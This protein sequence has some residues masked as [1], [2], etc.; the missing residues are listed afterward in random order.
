MHSLHDLLA[1]FTLHLGRKNDKFI[2]RITNN[3]A[4]RT[5]LSGAIIRQKCELV[6]VGDAKKQSV[7][8]TKFYD[9]EEWSI[10]YALLYSTNLIH[11][12]R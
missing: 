5:Y 2:D 8:Q 10:I 11:L 12:M 1:Q 7:I 6:P 9:C 4:R 3:S